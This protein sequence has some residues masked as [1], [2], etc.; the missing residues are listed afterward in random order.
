MLQRND[1]KGESNIVQN[2]FTAY[3]VV[4]VNRRK[5]TI[6]QNRR[7]LTDHELLIDDFQSF[8][9][10]VSEDLESE[11]L[12]TF[13]QF[14]LENA[15]LERALKQISSRERYVF[16]STA[17]KKRNFHELSKE[18]GIGYKGVAA[19]YYRTIQKLRKEMRGGDK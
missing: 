15:S 14:E 1:G 7:D 9:E 3:L 11:V 16:F 8:T 5:A 4:A 2:R 19:I 6:L 10:E 13:H 18:L 12:D 17:L